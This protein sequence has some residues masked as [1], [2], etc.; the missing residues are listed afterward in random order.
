MSILIMIYK[1]H[2]I[3]P[4]VSVNLT[5][6]FLIDLTIYISYRYIDTINSY[7]FEPILLII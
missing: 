4:H 1:I 3:L 2:I 7:T 5:I 6:V